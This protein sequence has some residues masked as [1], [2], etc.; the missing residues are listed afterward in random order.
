MQQIGID[1]ISAGGTIAFAMECYE[2]GI[3]SREEVDGLE[4]RFGNADA[5]IELIH[6]IARRE[7]FGN[8]L[9]EGSRCASMLIGKGV[10]RICN[11]RQ[12]SRDSSTRSPSFSR[13]RTTF[14][15]LSSRSRP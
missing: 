8:V 5:T 10:R 11:A 14:C 7:G 6:K 13:G 15:M 2:R 9:A 3:L 1:T 12:G 4:L